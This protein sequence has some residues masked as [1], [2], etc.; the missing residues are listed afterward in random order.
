MHTA[1]RMYNAA[2]EGSSLLM[3]GEKAAT[4]IE[5]SAA[6]HSVSLGAAIGLANAFARVAAKE[7]P[8]VLAPG[9]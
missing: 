1:A 5:R 4:E 7:R 2:K 8:P 9:P 3:E 6:R